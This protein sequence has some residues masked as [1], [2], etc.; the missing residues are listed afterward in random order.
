M[1]TI[2][3]GHRM[4]RNYTVYEL[5]FAD[6]RPLELHIFG[7]EGCGKNDWVLSTA[8]HVDSVLHEE[9]HDN[10]DYRIRGYLET[11]SGSE[12]NFEDYVY[13]ESTDDLHDMFL[14]QLKNHFGACSIR[15]LKEDEWRTVNDGRVN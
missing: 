13:H 6:N 9:K 2:P 12:Y 15:A 8:I 7:Y 1:I 5:G 11:R 4:V 3:P 14:D 10:S